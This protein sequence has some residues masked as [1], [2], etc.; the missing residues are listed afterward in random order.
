VDRTNRIIARKFF[1]KYIKRTELEKLSE[2]YKPGQILEVQGKVNDWGLSISDGRVLNENEYDLENFLDPSEI[3]PLEINKKKN[4]IS[5]VIDS[6]ENTWCRDLL[7]LMYNDEFFIEKFYKCPSSNGIH[8]SCPGGLSTHTVSMLKSFLEK[9]EFYKRNSNIDRDLVLVGIFVHDC[10]KIE[11]YRIK[12]GIIERTK[13]GILQ[14]HIYLGARIVEKYIDKIEDFP[15][16][17]RKKI[18][19][20][21][22]SHPGI[23]EYGAVELPQFVEAKIVYYLDSLDANYNLSKEFLHKI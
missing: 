8:H 19:H 6:I 5:R 17:L 2:I 20:I 21:I 16:D 11:E 1:N 9:E 12:N 15:E 23:K 14:G 13:K 22:L 7:N 4:F 3:N 10:G 18:V